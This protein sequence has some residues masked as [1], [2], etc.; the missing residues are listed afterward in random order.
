MTMPIQCCYRGCQLTVWSVGPSGLE[1]DCSSGTC[2]SCRRVALC[3]QHFETLFAQ[4]NH[5]RCP[6]CGHM[7]WFVSLFEPTR[8]SERLARSVRERGGR[9]EQR[10][11]SA[12][13]SVTANKVPTSTMGDSGTITPPAVRPWRWLTRSAL[14]DGTRSIAD[15][16]WARSAA[17]QTWLIV[18]GKPM[19]DAI[20]GEVLHAARAPG[21]AGVIVLQIAAHAQAESRFIWL[22]VSGQR[23]AVHPSAGR[24]LARPTFVDRNRFAYLARGADGTAE[25]RETTVEG[26]RTRTRRIVALGAI[27]D[28]PLPPAVF[29]NREAVVVFV[30]DDA[31]TWR[32]TR[33]RLADGR[34]G[35]IDAPQGKPRVL[36]AAPRG[37]IAAWITSDGE[38]RCAGP[39]IVPRVLGHTERDVLAC[40]DDG[41][42]VAWMVRDHLAVADP[43]T[44]EINMR[45]VPDDIISLHWAA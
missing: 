44:G 12:P 4:A 32:P 40:A 20:P 13:A 24:R 1:V 33:V 37:S 17:G 10:S 39:G 22:D 11:A 34:H 6:N 28:D 7:Q 36:A 9:I 2:M 18:D 23:G 21:T 45:N 43:R 29:Q 27:D 14:P 31:A 15:G 30:H 35:P 3:L 25:M 38:V 16:V 8:I 41:S 42:L 5:L 26:N 19:D